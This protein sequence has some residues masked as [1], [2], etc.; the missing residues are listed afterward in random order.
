ML[1]SHQ[2]QRYAVPALSVRQISPLPHLQK[3]VEY[4][5]PVA[6]LLNWRE[7]VIPVLDLSLC[8]GRRGRPLSLNDRL[9]VLEAEGQ[10]FGLIVEDCCEMRDFS[11]ETLRLP[12]VFQGPAGFP[13]YMKRAFSDRDGLCFLIDLPRLLA[14][15]VTEATWG[16]DDPGAVGGKNAA[17]AWTERE[18]RILLTRTRALQRG[19]HRDS[20]SGTRMGAVVVIGQESFWIDIRFVREFAP[21]DPLIPIPCTPPF[22][23]GV[24]KLRGQLITVFDLRT[25][26]GAAGEGDARQAGK[27]VVV[28]VDGVLAALLV[29]SVI[30][31][32]PIRP[33]KIRRSPLALQRIPEEYAGG[34]VQYGEKARATILDVARIL[35]GGDMEIHDE[36]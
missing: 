32:A 15:A 28:E 22:V 21:A 33:E 12:T 14:E 35:S 23:A 1:L 26:L 31:V 24:S 18:R 29:E 16:D 11:D 2:G 9:I 3:A 10:I 8:L 25:L 17:G 4:P 5:P 19:R 34:E 13:S 27:L 20:D 36:V 7:Q 6:G 30:D